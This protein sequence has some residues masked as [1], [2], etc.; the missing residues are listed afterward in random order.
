MGYHL[1]PRLTM[2]SFQK[3]LIHAHILQCLMV[4]FRGF[5]HLVLHSQL[6]FLI[7][8]ESVFMHGEREREI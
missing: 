1:T 4:S 8:L 6:K 2:G 7:H 5:I 3:L